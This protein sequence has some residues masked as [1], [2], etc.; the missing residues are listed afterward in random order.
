MAADQTENAGQSALTLSLRPGADYE[1]RGIVKSF[2]HVKV[3]RQVGV[4]F[5]PGEIHALVGENGAGKSTLLKIMAG[6]YS[7]DG[8][9]LVLGGTTMSALSPR[10]AQRHGIWLVPQ[11]PRLMPDLSVAENLYLGALPTGLLG[12]VAWRRMNDTTGE[13]TSS[14]GLHVSPRAAAAQL[15]LAQSQLLECARALSRGC[16]IIFFDEPTSPL[17][18]HDADQLFSLMNQ[19]RTRGLTL[20]FISH[21]LDEVDAISDKITV[22][23]DGT[24]IASEHSGVLTRQQIVSAMIG[25]EITVS[26]RHEHVSKPGPVMLETEALSSPPEVKEISVQV[27]SGE[28]VGM[29]GLVGSG[30]TEF[31]ET[32]FGIRRPSAGKVRVGGRDITGASPRACIDA[33]LIYLSEDRGRNGIF[34]DVDIIRNITSAVLGRL[35][36]RAKIF[37]RPGLE[38][39]MAQLG[40]R[41][42]DLRASSLGAPAR[43][44]SGGN[45]QKT[46][47]ARWMLTDPRVAILD[48]PT[49]GVDIGAK[50]SIYQITARL[51]AGGLAVLVISSELEE[52]VRLCHRVY[53]VYEG[54]IVG[55]LAGSEITLDAL[56]QLVVGA[57]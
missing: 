15:S 21:R 8:G 30:R 7:P 54:Q 25:R 16:G 5:R 20:G 10:E 6:V 14:V 2:A 26:R 11:E 28:I 55:E 27:H 45:Q 12:R 37:I 53:A 19:L 39:E 52:L 1:A 50:E 51:A 46:L 34:A 38:R 24:V 9:S 49:R 4:H 22:L 3:L 41:Q 47:L 57:A 43:T 33:G 56:G 13:L 29:A 18:A 35:P 36:R 17:T 40:A 48:E 44:L 32:V 42:T 31:A 23:R